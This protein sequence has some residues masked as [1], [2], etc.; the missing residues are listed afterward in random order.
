MNGILLI[1]KDIGITSTSC[2]NHVR[3][4]LE[5]KF[6]VGHAGTL[7][8]T[9]SGLLVLLIGKATRLS[10]FVMDLPKLYRVRVQLGSFT[11]TDDY[12]GEI[13]SSCGYESVSEELIDSLLFSFQ[14]TRMQVPP[15]IS[16]V[17]VDGKR[18]HE[19]ARSGERV[20]LSPK[21]I[22]VEY[23]RRISPLDSKMEFQLEVKCHK[24]TYIRSIARDIGR[25]LGSGAFV[26][27][28]ERFSIGIWDLD[29]PS[30]LRLSQCTGYEQIEAHLL[31]LNEMQHYYNT[32]SLS[33]EQ[34]ISARNGISLSLSDLS[35]L[36]RGIFPSANSLILRGENLFSFAGIREYENRSSYLVKPE[37]NINLDEGQR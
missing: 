4:C 31:S 6:K 15:G 19:L 10:R 18:A 13:L 12:S 16:A 17:S 20:S 11:D 25:L 9:A 7:D 1:R 27:S 35:P 22:Y 34:E 26:R 14:G 33:S 5:K 36:Q 37:T 2:V 30:T 29:H 32:Y 23:I 3:Q 21:P 24:G 28:L 8:S